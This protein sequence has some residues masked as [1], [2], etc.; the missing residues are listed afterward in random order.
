MMDIK[1]GLLLWFINFLIKK[2]SGS[3]VN[4][5]VMPKKQLAEELDKPIIIKF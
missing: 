1:E 5:Q 4:M 3:G 2:S